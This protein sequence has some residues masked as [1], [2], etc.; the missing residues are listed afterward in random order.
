ML[1]LSRS[2]RLQH[3]QKDSDSYA[4][5][6]SLS[7]SIIFSC[8]RF[9]INNQPSVFPLANRFKHLPFRQAPR[10]SLAFLFLAL[11][12]MAILEL[13]DSCF[14][15]LI[16]CV[17]YILPGLPSLNCSRNISPSVHVPTSIALSAAHMTSQSHNPKG[18]WLGGDRSKPGPRSC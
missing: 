3:E 9:I 6:T 14:S 8:F 7:K 16:A 13:I 15:A 4:K 17:S 12:I 2:S 5:R 1:N 11:L 18:Q 10:T